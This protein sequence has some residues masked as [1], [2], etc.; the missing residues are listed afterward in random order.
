MTTNQTT[1]AAGATQPV[2]SDSDCDLSDCCG[3]LFDDPGYPDNDICSAC[4]EHSAP[5]KEDGTAPTLAAHTPD[6]E[7]SAQR[8]ANGWR[9]VLGF[10]NGGRQ[11]FTTIHWT[12]EDALKEADNAWRLRIKYP[13]A[14]VRDPRENEYQ[15]IAKARA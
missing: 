10:A 14:C 7:I 3:A 11:V 5:A 9:A 6:I 1:N 13:H 4:N 2:F 8:D 15:E 12:M